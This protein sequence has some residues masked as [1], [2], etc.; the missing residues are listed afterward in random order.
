MQLPF[1]SDLLSSRLLFKSITIKRHVTTI[2]LFVLYVHDTRP[3][4]LT[5][6][7]AQRLLE[8]EKTRKIFGSDREQVT[9]AGKQLR[10]D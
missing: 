10:S 9:G 4:A 2:L 7:S 5:E 1:D 8:Q 3:L 6:V